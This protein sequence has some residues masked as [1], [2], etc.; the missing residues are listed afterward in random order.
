M[1]TIANRKTSDSSHWYEVSG[2]PCYELPKKDGSGMKVPTLADAKKLNLVPSVTTILKVLSKPALQDWL[3]EQ[4]VLAVLSTPRQEG[5]DLDA[6]VY[7]VL[8]V[9]RVQ[10][11]ESGLA[12]DRGTEIHAGLEA[13]FLGQPVAPDLL[14][15]V[16]PVYVALS[17]RGEVKAV[18]QVVVG[19]GYA[20]KVDLQLKQPDHKIWLYDYKTTRKLPKEPYPEARLQLSAY[21]ATIFGEL[22]RCANVYISTVTPGE[23]VI[24]EHENEEETFVEGF[25][26]LLRHWQWATGYKPL[27]S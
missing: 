9:E 26:P 23:F 15:W 22:W 13:M 5:E 2:K 7:R 14:L 4:A 8:H 1:T 6:F 12:R 19:D 17:K 16:A 27:Q 10:D 18:E 24:L 21:G 3:I 11:Q 20:G 25:Q